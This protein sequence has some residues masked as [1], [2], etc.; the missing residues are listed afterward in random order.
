MTIGIWKRHGTS[1]KIY[2]RLGG[3]EQQRQ[4]EMARNKRI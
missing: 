4:K 3:I 1:H 2:G